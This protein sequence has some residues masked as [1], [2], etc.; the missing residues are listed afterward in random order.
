MEYLFII[1]LV[2]FVIAIIA[3]IVQIKIREP[4]QI[5][6]KEKNGKF[7]ASLQKLYLKCRSL[8]LSC[9]ENFFE[10][11][12]KAT[13][14]GNIEIKIKLN[15]S[16]SIDFEKLDNLIKKGGWNEK[17]LQ[18]ATEKFMSM[19]IGYLKSR[20][21]KLEIEEIN[22]EKID[23]LIFNAKKESAEFGISI[24]NFS[25]TNLEILD[26]KAKEAIRAKESARLN[27]KNEE[28]L[29]NL[30]YDIEKK[31]C[32]LE[33][34]LLE[35]KKNLSSQK[36]VL[37]E[38]EAENEN[39]IKKLQAEF[40]KEIQQIKLEVEKQE[41][42]LLKKHPELLLFSPQAAR[43]IEASQSLK[44]ARTIVNLSGEA[45]KGVDISEALTDLISSL[46]KKDVEK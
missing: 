21:E 39:H 30:K 2:L 13:S 29:Q 35:E 10:S 1:L 18:N 22:L 7:E 38:I 17:A 15:G 46:I 40:E 14:S 4:H 12:F 37:N 24:K 27:K 41:L 23:Y 32:E 20:I 42:E 45:A 8:P 28:Y 3:I 5:I 36:K 43:L 9:E 34:K 44:N 16:A 19:A 31:K 11:E 6:V 25:A 33:L 26:E